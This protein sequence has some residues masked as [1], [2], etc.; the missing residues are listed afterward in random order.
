MRLS[1]LPLNVGSPES[2]AKVSSH[3]Q[4]LNPKDAVC[5][6]QVYYLKPHLALHQS[7]LCAILSLFQGWCHLPH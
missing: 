7:G 5:I 1:T 2:R 6:L 4:Y 3:P